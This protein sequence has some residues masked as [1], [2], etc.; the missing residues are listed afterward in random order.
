MQRVS[1][2]VAILNHGELIAQAPIEELLAGDGGIVYSMVVKGDSQAVHD[3]LAQQSWVS[4][5]E[6]VPSNGHATLQI[7]VTNEEAAEA[8]L[9]QLVMA[10]GDVTVTEFGRKQRN[11]EETF[12]NIIE[13]SN[14]G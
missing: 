13:G 10:G 6:V 2:T 1:D 4:G 3:R 8:Q 14:N 9:L 12:M 5:I 11:L 7:S